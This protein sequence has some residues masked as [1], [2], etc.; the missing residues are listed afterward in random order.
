MVPPP[1]KRLKTKG[2][3]SP[4]WKKTWGGH[5][6]PPQFFDFKKKARFGLFIFPLNKIA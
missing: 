6:S 2:F 3:F 4:P 5:F 1:P